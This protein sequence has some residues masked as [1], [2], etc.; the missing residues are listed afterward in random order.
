MAHDWKMPVGIKFL[1]S[2]IWQTR[3]VPRTVLR[4]QICGEQERHCPGAQKL[5]LQG[6]AQARQQKVQHSRGVPWQGKYQPSSNPEKQGPR[7]PRPLSWWKEGSQRWTE[8]KTLP[9]K[10]RRQAEK[11][12][13][14]REGTCV[15]GTKERRVV[16]KRGWHVQSSPSG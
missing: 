2:W 13:D 6:R 8:E 4:P 5:G 16:R 9:Q 14:T 11:E 15:M 3:I 7:Q 10:A 1:H 12:E